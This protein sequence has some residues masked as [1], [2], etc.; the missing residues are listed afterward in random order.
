MVLPNLCNHSAGRF[1][2]QICMCVAVVNVLFTCKVHYYIF[3]SLLLHHSILIIFSVLLHHN[4]ILKLSDY[5]ICNGGT[6]I[7][8]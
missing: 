2:R 8:R 3:I 1:Y 6:K 5:G 4:I 7:P